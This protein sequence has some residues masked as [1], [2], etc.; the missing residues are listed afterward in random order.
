MDR[1]RWI[2]VDWAG[3]VLSVSR[4]FRPPCDVVWR[5]FDTAED[6]EDYLIDLLGLNYEYERGE[7]RVL[8]EGELK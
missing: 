6:A 1:E 8:E 7:Y 4:K 2:I 5:K 3:N